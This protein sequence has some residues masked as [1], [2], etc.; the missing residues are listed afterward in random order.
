MP[1]QQQVGVLLIATRKYKQFVKPLLDDLEQKF[2]LHHNVTVYLFTDEV[3]TYSNR[4][5]NRIKVVEHLIDPYKWPYP[6]LYRYKIFTSRKYPECDYLYYFDVDVAIADTLGDDIFGNIVAVAHCGFYTNGG[7]SW[8]T[9]KESET[10]V[11]PEKRKKYFAGGFQ[12]GRMTSYYAAML[13]MKDMIDT[14]ER[15]GIIPIWHDESAWNCY[16]S[17]LVG[18]T[19]LPPSYCLV[20]PIPLRRSWGVDQFE[21]KI[22]ALAKDHKAMRS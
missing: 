7:G 6:T 8:E 2:L 1:E 18:F 4:S 11:P 20:E 13:I 15:N 22:V 21:P 9:R 14:D 16:L 5:K 19:E 17:N 3:T 12:G 10:Y